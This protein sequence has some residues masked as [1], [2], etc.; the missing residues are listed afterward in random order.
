MWY[1]VRF[2]VVIMFVVMAVGCGSRYNPQTGMY[3]VYGTSKFKLPEGYSEAGS[4]NS[5]IIPE[6]PDLGSE[7]Y[8]T[9]NTTVFAKNDAYIFSQQLR[10]TGNKYYIRPLKGT[11][12]SKWDT[13]WRKGTYQVDPDR[14]SLEYRRYFDYLRKKGEPVAPSY[15]V[16]MYDR[17]V[18]RHGISRVMFFTPSGPSGNQSL[19]PAKQLYYFDQDDFRQR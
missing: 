1:A 6:V 4:F 5:T 16:T 13:S 2:V 3:R 9:F 12:V 14:T 8:Q 15:K 19:P 17:L 11:G 10:V 7:P 18:G